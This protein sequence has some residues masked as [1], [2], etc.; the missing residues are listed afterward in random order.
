MQLNEEFQQLELITN[1]LNSS[2]VTLH[3]IEQIAKNNV[4]ISSTPSTGSQSFLYLH[5]E[6]HDKKLCGYWVE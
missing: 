2:I 3:C 5:D 1:G 6:L 4:D